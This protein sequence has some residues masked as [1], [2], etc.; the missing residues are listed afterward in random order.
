MS[1]KLR[2]FGRWT[3][4]GGPW[5]SELLLKKI[6]LYSRSQYVYFI[7]LN[8]EVGLLYNNKEEAG[9]ILYTWNKETVVANFG[10]GHPCRGTVFRPKIPARGRKLWRTFSAHTINT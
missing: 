9:F 5:W 7:D 3:Q 1:K 4:K 2:A 8:R 6:L 10:R